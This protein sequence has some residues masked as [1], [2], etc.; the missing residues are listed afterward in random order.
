MKIAYD[1]MYLYKKVLIDNNNIFMFGSI[2]GVVGRSLI[3][4]L[5]DDKP[6]MAFFEPAMRQYINGDSNE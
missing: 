4:K 1:I 3:F 2:I 6:M 5:Y